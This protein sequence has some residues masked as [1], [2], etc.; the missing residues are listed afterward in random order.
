M[1]IP[2]ILSDQPIKYYPA[3]L[4]TKKCWYVQYSVFDPYNQRMVSKRIK[5]NRIKNITERRRFAHRL[6][7]ELNNKLENGWNPFIKVE[8]KRQF[9]KFVDV[10]KLYK[11][12]E[13]KNF[14]A[15]T[16][17]TLDSY[18]VKLIEFSDKTDRNLLAGSFTELMA[19]NLMME[20]KLDE[21]IGSRTY[22]NNL[23]FFKRFFNWMVVGKFTDENPFRNIPP[24]PKRLIK[25]TRKALTRE[26]IRNLVEYLEI[27]NPRFLAACLLIYYCL[28]RPDDLQH[29]KPS[30][31][32]F[33]NKT[34]RINA[35]N[36]KNDNN[37]FRVIP[38]V[39]ERY[40]N[41]LDIEN[42]NPD[43]YIFS[44][45][46]SFLFT[47]GRT[48]IDKR[49]FAKYWSE[50]IRPALNFG[51]ELQFYSL[52]D[53]GI[54]NLM[55]DGISPVFVQKQADHSSLETTNLYTDKN[56]PEGYEQLR[57]LAKPV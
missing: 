13:Y 29:L 24:I 40:L 14:E 30:S 41:A 42:T 20:I 27:N 48:K 37:S 52:K 9:E 15:E 16:I 4:Y 54:T 2:Q 8:A 18:F 3:E 47:S 28:L 19:S 6:K 7:R 38:I 51:K 1:S 39:L 17:R 56:L 10:I 12:A 11:K 50:I 44:E 55:S 53:S 25:K 46:K 5:I 49:Y 31:F 32:D 45:K 35:D 22:N 34:I 21:K 26:E 57:N 33:K 36:T 23:Q 43:Y